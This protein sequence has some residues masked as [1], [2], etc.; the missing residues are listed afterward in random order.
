MTLNS[1]L[2]APQKRRQLM[3]L[4]VGATGLLGSEICQLLV[5]GGEPVRA[6]IRSSSDSTK[7]EK[8]RDLGVEIVE[9]DLKDRPSLTAACRGASAVI[10]TA[11]STLSRQK[12]DSIQSVDREGQLDLIDA[13]K[14][15][16]VDRFV[17]VSF[18]HMDVEFPLQT[19][20]RGVEQHLKE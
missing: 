8:L 9:G 12:G 6:L 7:V 19:A 15:A 16:E 5:A 18:H 17:L 13:A 11:S 3:V 10:S 14:A 4:V 1:L 20:K 2:Y